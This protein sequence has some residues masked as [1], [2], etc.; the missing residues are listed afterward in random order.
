MKV[1]L[2]VP[3]SGLTKLNQTANW[4]AGIPI[5]VG[6]KSWKYRGHEGRRWCQAMEFLEASRSFLSMLV[7]WPRSGCWCLKFA[8]IRVIWGIENS[9]AK[10]VNFERFYFMNASAQTQKRVRKYISR[11]KR[12]FDCQQND[13]LCWPILTNQQAAWWC[14]ALQFP[15]PM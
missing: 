12:I 5:S 10:K 2:L 4:R 7:L 14:N 11:N 1:G 9:A 8:P 15:Y 13:W 3:R 6:P